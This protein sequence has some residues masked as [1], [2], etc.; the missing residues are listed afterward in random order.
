MEQITW[1]HSDPGISFAASSGRITIFKTTL[2]AMGYPP[3]FRFLLDTD[4]KQ[5][6]IECCGFESSG[7]HQLPERI[8]DDHYDIKCMD[9]VRFI[10]QTCGWDMKSTYRI[11][12]IPAPD[13]RMIV[14][15]LTAALIV[16]E[17]MRDE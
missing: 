4:H 2:K 13:H 8:A 10:Y 5:F 1:T 7:S 9:L 17:K 12:G 11:K 14:F 6:G 3:Y 16:A 15:D